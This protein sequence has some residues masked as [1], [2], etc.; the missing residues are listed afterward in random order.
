MANDFERSVADG[1]AVVYHESGRPQFHFTARRNSLNAPNGLVYYEGEYH[2][3]FQHNPRGNSWGN[4]TWGHAVS[5]DLVTWR[6]LDNAICPDSQGTI[7]SGSAVVDHDDTAGFQT[8]PEPAIVAMYTAAGG[9]S[10]ESEGQ[11][12]TQCLAYSNDRGRTL[13]KYAGNPVLPHVVGENR[14]PKAIWFAPGRFWVMALFLDR[15][16][17]ALFTSQ[18]LKQWTRIQTI[19][20][21][22]SSECPDF[23]PMA[24][25]GA[26]DDERWIF[27]AANG[28][29]LVGRFDGRQ[30][31]DI[32]GPFVMDFGAN[33]YGAQTFS[34]IPA[35]DGRRIQIG[36]MAGGVYP[37]MPF[38]Q[39]MSFPVELTLRDTQEGLRLFRWP[40][41][42]I[43]SIGGDARKWRDITVTPG[44]NPLAGID[45]DLLDI[46]AEIRCDPPTV[47]GF[48]IGDREIRYS[49]QDRMVSCLGRTARRTG[50]DPTIA[51]RIL[52]DRTSIEIFVDGGR[53]VFSFCVT[54]VDP[55]SPLEFFVEGAPITVVALDVRALRS[56]WP[57]ANRDL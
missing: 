47:F 40:V 21:P 1:D 27:T 41:A 53:T 3:F 50:D 54:P 16:C 55:Q 5:T 34:D 45:S 44:E 26:P 19:V 31:T 7:Y 51:L 2:M 52:A 18:D 35:S 42:E 38:N 48:R 9:T 56:I 13:T 29:Y 24:V 46:S 20:L 37:G 39:Q 11:P 49:A 30:F 25:Q 4:M 8:G 33:F 15:E 43:A 14:D 23:F 36:W 6:Q 28:H 32:A 10:P 22:N 12:F 57:D 17:F